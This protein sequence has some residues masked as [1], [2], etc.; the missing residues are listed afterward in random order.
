MN[1]FLKAIGIIVIVVLTLLILAPLSTIVGI[2]GGWIVGLF[3]TDLI[4]GTIAR[5]GFDVTGLE[6]WHIGGVLGFIASFFKSSQ[7]NTNK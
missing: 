5:T 1:E 7:T 4:I 3:F 6:V 2:I